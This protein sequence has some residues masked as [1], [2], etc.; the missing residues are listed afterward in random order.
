VLL[1]TAAPL[2]ALLGW[3][4]NFVIQQI[5]PAAVAASGGDN[6]TW[7]IV[8]ASALVP[9]IITV[10]IRRAVKEPDSWVAKSQQQQTDAGPSEIAQVFGI[11]YRK[12]TIGAIVMAVLSLS[13][14]WICSTFIPTVRSSNKSR[15][16]PISPI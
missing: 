13:A 11:E 6:T 9:T 3:L 1:Y 5:L 4:V 15:S 12:R 16:Y 2:G 8:F 7:R 10:F 14:W